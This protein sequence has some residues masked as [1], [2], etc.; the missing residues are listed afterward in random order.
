MITSSDSTSNYYL[1]TSHLTEFTIVEL[2]EENYINFSIITSIC[3]V[4][5]TLL[6]ALACFFFL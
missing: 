2:P 1:Q 3:S 4:S 5:F 6:I